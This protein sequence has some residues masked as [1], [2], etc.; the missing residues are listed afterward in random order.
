MN[1]KLETA[2]LIGKILYV[3]VN[4]YLKINFD[5]HATSIMAGWLRTVP[6]G[7]Q[8]KHSHLNGPLPKYSNTKSLEMT[9]VTS[10]T[11]TP[12]CGSTCVSIVDGGG[13]ELPLHL[14]LS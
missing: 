4:G 2:I 10:W 7:D 6:R 1:V 9:A 13:C 11:W 8:A 3:P 5:L 14:K 12:E